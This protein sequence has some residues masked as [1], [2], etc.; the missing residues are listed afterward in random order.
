VLRCLEQPD[1]AGSSF[2]LPGGETLTVAAMLERS[3]RSLAPQVRL[4]PTPLW[5][6][7]LAMTLAARVSGRTGPVR[8]IVRR[9]KR[10]QLFDGEPARLAF[11]YDPRPFRP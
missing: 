1:T 8:G 7:G 9:L 4:L 3:A 11:G 6:F 2:D 5:V 10:D